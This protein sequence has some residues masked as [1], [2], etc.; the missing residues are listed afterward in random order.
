MP[1]S[2]GSARAPPHGIAIGGNRPVSALANPGSELYGHRAPEPEWY[3][4][5]AHKIAAI[6]RKAGFTWANL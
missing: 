1:K 2:G 4:D 6:W 3:L 5:L